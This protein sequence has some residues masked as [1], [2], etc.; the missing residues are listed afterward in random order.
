MFKKAGCH[1]TD[2]PRVEL[3]GLSDLRLDRGVVEV[4]GVSEECGGRCGTNLR[5]G[6]CG[7]REGAVVSS[8]VGPTSHWESLEVF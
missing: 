4:A 8:G 5:G 1:Y 7:E 2:L 3:M 6:G